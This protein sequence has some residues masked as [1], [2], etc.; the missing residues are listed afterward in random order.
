MQRT[1]RKS[2]NGIFIQ[3]IINPRYLQNTSARF[4]I[5]SAKLRYFFRYVSV[6]IGKAGSQ[7][8]HMGCGS[9]IGSPAQGIDAIT[10]FSCRTYKRI[11]YFFR[12][13]VKTYDNA[14]IICTGCRFKLRILKNVLF[15][16]GPSYGIYRDQFPLILR[17]RSILLQV[18]DTYPRPAKSLRGLWVCPRFHFQDT[19]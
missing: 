19:I 2:R 18:S 8:K 7:I 3:R 16:K 5:C 1:G 6:L 15:I 11:R 10:C 9:G 17:R 12:L 13:T 4:Y 14:G